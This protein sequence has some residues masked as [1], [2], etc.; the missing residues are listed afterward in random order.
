MTKVEEVWKDINGFEGRYQISNFGRVKSLGH[1]DRLNR[2]FKEIVL[3]QAINA[4]GYRCVRIYKDGLN[5]T[6][7]IH[8]LV[9]E[10]FIPTVPGKTII[11]HKDGNK[12]NNSI[13]NLEWCTYGENM[14]HAIRTGLNSTRSAVAVR[15]ETGK[16]PIEQCDSR[17][18]RLNKFSSAADASRETGIN[19]GNIS[20][21]CN[22]KKEMAGDFVWK[23]AT[24]R[25]EQSC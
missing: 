25:G 22:G 15:A 19:R 20:S 4:G 9:S 14:S 2:R 16:K 3:K 21:C 12:L 11:N 1:N 17:G 5:Y 13:E 10:A 23:F 6:K 18:N 7:K 24:Y 8:R